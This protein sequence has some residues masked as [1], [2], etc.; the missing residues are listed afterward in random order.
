MMK[1]LLPSSAQSKGQES[2]CRLGMLGQKPTCLLIAHT[3][4]PFLVCLYRHILF[5]HSACRRQKACCNRNNAMLQ[6]QKMARLAA[7]CCLAGGA[8]CVGMYCTH[9]VHAS[10]QHTCMHATLWD[11]YQSPKQSSKRLGIAHSCKNYYCCWCCSHA[12]QD[13]LLT[14]ALAGAMGRLAAA[15]PRI[16]AAIAVLLLK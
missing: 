16:G 10:L 2:M 3:R 5:T 6:L 14:I 9:V 13:P 1:I 8:S 7:N 4:P 15:R 12:W 11:M